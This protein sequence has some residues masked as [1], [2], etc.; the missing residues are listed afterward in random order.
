MAQIPKLTD[1]EWK[2]MIE[3]VGPRTVLRK[4]AS[5]INPDSENDILGQV[6]G[7]SVS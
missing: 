1:A 2:E 6:Q 4:A 3:P 5:E 7:A